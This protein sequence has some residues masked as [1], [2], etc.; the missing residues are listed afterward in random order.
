MTEQIKNTITALTRNNME[1]CFVETKQEALEKVLSYI[2]SND[3]VAVGGSMTLKEIG[4][5]DVLRNGE[6]N[7]LDRYSVSNPDDIMKVY[8]DSMSADVYMSSSNA[9]TENGE[10]Y[11]VDGN[12]NRVA[13][14]TFGP[15]SVIIVAGVNKIVK[16]L[17]E[18]VLRVKTV[19]AP[20]NCK[21]LNK[22]TYCASFGKCQSIDSGNGTDMTAG[23][24]GDD[25][26]CC[27]YVVCGQ[28]RVKNRI[29]VILVGEELGY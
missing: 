5:L 27:S 17:D 14:I 21:R 4:V 6:Y 25:R 9:I 23:C 3:S 15:K 26:I 1:A 19:A 28:Q 8:F 7:F 22:K 2:K 29:K 16:S 10:L 11:N 24:G 20:L 18:A 13:A 12:C